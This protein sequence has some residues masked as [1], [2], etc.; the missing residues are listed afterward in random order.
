M[1]ITVEITMRRILRWNFI[2]E[3]M[4]IFDFE[5][6]GYYLSMS[7]RQG[8]CV[9]DDPILLKEIPPGVEFSLENCISG[10]VVVPK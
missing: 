4:L 6:E 7:R 1:E 9:K 2:W 8:L 3:C 10:L 5:P